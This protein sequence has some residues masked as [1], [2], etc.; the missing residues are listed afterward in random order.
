MPDVFRGERDRPSIGHGVAR[1]DGEIDQRSVKLGRIDGDRP[2]IRG[3]VGQERNAA[4][5]PAAQDL[6]NHIDALA[7]IDRFRVDALTPRKCQ[8]LL[9]E[10]RTPLC[11]K[12]NG[13]GRALC[14]GIISGG[15][16]QGL[17]MPGYHHQQIVEVVGDAARELPKRV[18]FL[19]FRELALDLL[20]GLL[21]LT[22][23]GDVARDLCKS[24][25]AAVVSSLSASITTL[26][27]KNEPSLRTR[28]PSSS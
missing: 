12:L 17:N 23:F 24:D 5:Q 6:A 10:G 13:L 21:R 20:Q 22:A 15:L 25:E 26:A 8:K 2:R 28:H 3:D 7:D 27:Q 9:G 18:H 14:L 4:S 1:V 11:R 19:R 16:F